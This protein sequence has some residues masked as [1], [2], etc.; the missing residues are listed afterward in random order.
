VFS[1]NVQEEEERRS[2]SSMSKKET[3]VQ[4][5][6]QLLTTRMFVEHLSV[7][8]ERYYRDTFAISPDDSK[9]EEKKLA[10]LEQLIHY[11]DPVEQTITV[12]DWLI[13]L[14]HVRV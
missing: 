7:L 13:V 1:V 9:L 12:H 14:Q 4:K 3:H 5:Q 11:M 8:I 6:K 10:V 2:K